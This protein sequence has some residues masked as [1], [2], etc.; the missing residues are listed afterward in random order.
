MIYFYRFGQNEVQFDGEFGDAIIS[1]LFLRAA[2]DSDETVCG[3]DSVL[4]LINGFCRKRELRSQL[5]DALRAHM[6]AIEK[7]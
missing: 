6:F 5:V 2:I 3:D 7:F 4:A 1:E